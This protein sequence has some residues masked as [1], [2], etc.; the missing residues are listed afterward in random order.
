[1]AKRG[2]KNGAAARDARRMPHRD[3]TDI[4]WVQRLDVV[5]QFC[6]QCSYLILQHRRGA[7]FAL[8]ACAHQVV[9]L[10][11][12]HPLL[13]RTVTLPHRL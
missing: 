2:N 13:R 4:T 12:R 9:Q 3:A 10:P 5:Q 6:Q 11:T 1:M 7:Q 8:S